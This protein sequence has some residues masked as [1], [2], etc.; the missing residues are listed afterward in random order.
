MK[1]FADLLEIARVL[2]RDLSDNHCNNTLY[3]ALDGTC[4]LSKKVMEQYVINA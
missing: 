3:F 4:D 1:S 2:F